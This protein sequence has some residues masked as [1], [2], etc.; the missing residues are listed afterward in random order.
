MIGLYLLIPT[1]LAILFSYLVVR[2]GA[3][4]LMMTGMEQSKAR[5][6]ALS[7][8]TRAGFTTKEAELVINHPQ[9]R[10]II[11][12]LIIAGNAGLVAVIV[13]A[14]SSIATSTGYNLPITIAVLI[15]SV[16]VF[17]IYLGRSGFARWWDSFIEKRI[18]KS[19]ILEEAATEDLLHFIEGY[20]LVKLIVTEDSIFV[21][22]SLRDV[23]TEDNEF[24]VLGIERGKEWI[25]IPRAREVINGG[26]KLVIFGNLDNLR[27]FF[28]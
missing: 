11:T 7:A 9:R 22:H 8:F 23:N 2:A 13:T 19:Q 3:I 28:H 5:F 10:R 21:G 24:F 15:G 20:G 1:L 14:T 26:D 27:K 6:Q 4:A 17:Y 12:W 25:S 16:L 18:V